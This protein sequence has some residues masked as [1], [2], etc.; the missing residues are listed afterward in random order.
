MC[1][2]VTLG[3]TAALGAA[4]MGVNALGANAQNQAASQTEASQEAQAIATY[5]DNAAAAN[6]SNATLQKFLTQQ[7]ANQQAN[8]AAFAPTMAYYT[9]ATYQANQA[10]I[11]KTNAATAVSG[12]QA[13]LPNQLALPDAH[14]SNTDNGQSA[15]AIK[16]AA[17]TRDNLAE[18]NATNQAN[19]ASY[20]QALTGG[21]LAAASSAR[22][23]DEQNAIARSEASMLPTDEQNAALQARQYVAPAQTSTALN[24][25]VLQGV[26]NLLGSL[27]G[28][29]S[30]Q[31]GNAIN[32]GVSSLG[33]LFNGSL[34]T[35]AGGG[36]SS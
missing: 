16:T 10:N 22:Q 35:A 1:D 13:L 7:T 25:P 34:D 24:V 12:I 27:A 5:K 23:I 20:G 30:G 3:V 4:G 11:A 21:N 15:A 29:Q 26:G 36:V 32:N 8:N 18:T 31:I 14:L 33:S 19:L 28:S 2:P 9:P 6:A 17:Q